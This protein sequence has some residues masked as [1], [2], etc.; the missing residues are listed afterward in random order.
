MFSANLNLKGCMS[1]MELSLDSL[2]LSAPTAFPLCT[3]C[4]LEKLGIPLGNCWPFRM[5]CEVRSRE[6]KE[7]EEHILQLLLWNSEW[8]ERQLFMRSFEAKCGVRKAIIFISLPP[9]TVQR[10]NH[11][12]A[13][14]EVRI[15]EVCTCH[16]TGQQVSAITR[17]GIFVVKVHENLLI[18][19][20]WK[21]NN[22]F[23]DF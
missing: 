10:H 1:F 15:L 12:Q 9:L 6:R 16:V 23:T 4:S 17:L 18:F 7:G 19:S 14:P 3:Q 11:G 22:K 8:S 5:K 20:F 21:N 2:V 13:D